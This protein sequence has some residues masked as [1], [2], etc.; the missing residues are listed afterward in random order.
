MQKNIDRTIARKKKVDQYADIEIWITRHEGL[1][2][3]HARM[4]MMDARKATNARI[5]EAR[6]NI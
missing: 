6:S 2:L 5:T 3:D 4:T 1:S